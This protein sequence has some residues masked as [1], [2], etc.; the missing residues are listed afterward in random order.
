LSGFN[1]TGKRLYNT[2]HAAGFRVCVVT[3]AHPVFDIRIFHKQAKALAKAGYEVT[4]IAPHDRNEAV[5]GIQIL[6]LPRSR[7]RLQRWISLLRVLKLVLAHHAY[8]YHLHDPELLFVGV[9]LKLLRRRARVIYDVHEDY[10]TDILSKE[11][12]PPAWRG[13]ISYIFDVIEKK[14][15]RCFDGVVAATDYIQGRFTAHRVI[16][17]RNY[18]PLKLLKIAAERSLTSGPPILIYVGSLTAVRGIREIVEA[19]GLLKT[20]VR[21]TLIGHW[22][23]KGFKAAVEALRG[24]ERVDYLGTLPWEEVWP[25]LASASIGLVCFHPTPAHVASG[26]NK[27][28]EYMAAGIPVIASNFPHWRQ[29]IESTGC[30]LVVDPLDPAQIAQAIEYLLSHPGQSRKMGRQGQKQ[31]AERF[32]WENEEKR[33]LNFYEQITHS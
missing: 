5:A 2:I 29:I 13:L 24:F 20:D 1:M 10:R 32:N 7:N 22:V 23:D 33:L 9:I 6:A 30:G 12:I 3:S 11:W 27:L 18:P 21:L 25:H 8:V 26:P 31:V 17:V 15:T 4:V 16:A 14:L 19:I 28:F